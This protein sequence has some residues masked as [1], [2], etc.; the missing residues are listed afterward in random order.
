MAEHEP[1]IGLSSDWYTPREIFDA[2]GLVFDLDPCSPGRDHWVPAHRIYTVA[3]DG[4]A[5]PWAGLVFMNPPFGG[6]NG[7]V[8][9]L[10][11]F[12]E[13]ANGIAIVRAYTSSAWFYQWAIKAELMLFPKGKTK[14]VRPDGSIG[15]APGHGVVLLGMGEPARTALMRSGLGWCASPTVHKQTS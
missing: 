10:R 12:L 1:S 13:H 7:H 5:K 8:P 3:D 14:F 15:R 6:R 4:L 11:K 2:L 9:W